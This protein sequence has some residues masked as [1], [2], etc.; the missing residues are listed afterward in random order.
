MNEILRADDLEN[1]PHEKR[2]SSPGR[3]MHDGRRGK[4]IHLAAGFKAT[5]ASGHHIPNPL[6]I[7]SVCE[8]DDKS[9]RHSKDV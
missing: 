7:S 8:S 9:V 1:D 3:I 5:S 4:L 2:K 6:A